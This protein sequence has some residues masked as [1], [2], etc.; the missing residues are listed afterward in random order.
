MFFLYAANLAEWEGFITKFLN[1]IN[2]DSIDDVSFY[3]YANG[4]DS[5]SIK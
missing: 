1:Y 2:A 5:P 3:C 4:I